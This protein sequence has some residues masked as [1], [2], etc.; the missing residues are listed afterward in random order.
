MRAPVVLGHRGAP[1]DRVENTLDSFAWA[2]ACGAAGI[3]CDLRLAADGEVVVFHD[4]DLQ[5]LAG[6]AERVDELDWPA[7][8]QVELRAGGRIPRLVDLLAAWPA[9]AWLDLELKAGGEALA[10]AVVATVAAR[11]RS[12]V[13]S[14]DPSLLQAVA[15]TGWSGQRW[16]LLELSPSADPREHLD[17]AVA[18]GVA[19]VIVPAVTA[20]SQAVEQYAAANLGMGVWGARDDEHE[21]QLA[22]CG[23]RWLITDRPRAGL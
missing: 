15:S 13:S 20:S 4:H 7:L 10:R 23:L 9:A 18:L 3:E 17:R 2:L 22:T 12:F 11:Q 5:R 8:A 19:G 1:Q 21:R 16:L 14:F 6:R